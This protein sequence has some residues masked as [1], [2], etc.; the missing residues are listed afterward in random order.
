MN[1]EETVKVPLAELHASIVENVAYFDWTVCQPVAGQGLI[2]L[3]FLNRGLGDT[4]P[5]IL[6]SGDAAKALYEELGKALSTDTYGKKIRSG[7]PKPRA[8]R[9]IPKA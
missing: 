1:P 8:P 3:V 4:S 6:L 5:S 2:E 7:L 9:I